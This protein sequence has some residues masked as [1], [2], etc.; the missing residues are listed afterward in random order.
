MEKFSPSERL[1]AM[2]MKRTASHALNLST[3]A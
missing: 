3:V 1:H 2:D